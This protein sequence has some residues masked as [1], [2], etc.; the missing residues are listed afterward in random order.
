MLHFLT[1]SALPS[2]KELYVRVSAWRSANDAWRWNPNATPAFSKEQVQNLKALSGMLDETGPNQQIL[3]AEIAR[4]M[5]EFDKCLLL[6]SQPFD[7]RYGHAVGFRVG[8]GKKD[9]RLSENSAL[10]DAAIMRPSRR[11]DYETTQTESRS[12]LQSQG[13]DSGLAR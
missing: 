3:K 8:S 4:E 6:L 11:A 13:G 9:R 7:E 2:D 10:L 12:S 1:G 5:G